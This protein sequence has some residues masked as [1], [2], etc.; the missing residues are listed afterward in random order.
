MNTDLVLVLVLLVTAIALFVRG[1]PRMDMVAL[2]MIAALP[3]TGTVTVGEAIAGFSDPNIVL[4]AFL[5]VLGE[6]LVRTGV[7]RRLG[8]WINATARRRSIRRC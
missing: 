6:G 3:L 1:R 8:D 7:A 4:I 5:F 2:I